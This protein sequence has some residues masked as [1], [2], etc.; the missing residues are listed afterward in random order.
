MI[1]VD[2]SRGVRRAKPAVPMIPI[3]RLTLALAAT[4]LLL[5]VHPAAGMAACANPV[6][7]ENEKPGSAPSAWQVTGAGDSTIQGYAT[8]MSVNKGDAIGFKIKTPSTNYHIDIYRLGY[9]Q[10]NGARLQASNIRPTATLP[11][12]QPNCLSDASTGLIDCGNWAVSASWTVPSTSVSGVYIARLV[13]DDASGAASQIPFV[14]RDDS[15]NAAVLVRTSDAT[16]QAYNKY[17]GNSL[18]SCTSP[19]C[20]PGNPRAYQGAFKV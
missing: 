7:C 5:A 19:L 12:N 9:Y 16:W 14:V 18:Y 15:A 3:L 2:R 1:A 4:I 11:Q 6:A 13:R 17:G 20:P 8:S 10:G